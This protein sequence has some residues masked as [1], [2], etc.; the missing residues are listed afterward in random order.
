MITVTSDE[1]ANVRILRATLDKIYKNKRADVTLHSYDKTVGLSEE[2]FGTEPEAMRQPI[3]ELPLTNIPVHYKCQHGTYDHAHN[4]FMPGEEVLILYTG[5]VEDPSEWNCTLIGYPDR[6]KKCVVAGFNTYPR[7][8]PMTGLQYKVGE[9]FPGFGDIYTPYSVQ[10]VA[11]GTSFNTIYPLIDDDGK[12]RYI[13]S[14]GSD[15]LDMVLTGDC[16]NID[17]SNDDEEDL[18]ILTWKGPPSRYFP[19]PSNIEIPGFTE[20]DYEFMTG[21]GDMVSRYMPWSHK[22]YRNGEVIAFGPRNVNYPRNDDPGAINRYGKIIGA[23]LAPSGDKEYVVAAVRSCYI[24]AP[25]NLYAV[26]RQYPEESEGVVYSWHDTQNEADGVVAAQEVIGLWEVREYE[27]VVTENGVVVGTFTDQQEATDFVA[28]Q[29]AVVWTVHKLVSGIWRVLKDGKVEKEFS[30]E[31]EAYA[32]KQVK[33]T[34]TWAITQDEW[35]LTRDGE[36]IDVFSA[37]EDALAAKQRELDATWSVD[38]IARKENKPMAFYVELWVAEDPDIE[39]NWKDASHPG[40]WVEVAAVAV[41]PDV[42]VFFSQDGT[43]C[44]SIMKGGCLSGSVNVGDKPT[45]S[46]T[47]LDNVDGV[48]VHDGK[49]TFKTKTENA[50]YLGGLSVTSYGTLGTGM[51]QHTY[52]TGSGATY[53]DN[54]G[55]IIHYHFTDSDYSGER[56]SKQT[57]VFEGTAAADSIVAADYKNNEVVTATVNVEGAFRWHSPYE[58]KQNWSPLPNG[59]APLRTGLPYGQEEF[60]LGNGFYWCDHAWKSLQYNVN[61]SYKK[62]LKYGDDELVLQD[63]SRLFTQDARH[64]AHSTPGDL[65]WITRYVPGR[66]NL[67]HDYYTKVTGGMTNETYWTSYTTESYHYLDVVIHFMDLRRDVILYR[68]TKDDQNWKNTEQDG[69]QPDNPILMYQYGSYGQA[70]A[71]SSPPVKRTLETKYY[72]RAAGASGY[73]GETETQERWLDPPADFFPMM[74]H[75]RWPHAAETRSIFDFYALSS[76]AVGGDPKDKTWTYMKPSWYDDVGLDRSIENFEYDLMYNYYADENA[77]PDKGIPQHVV[78]VLYENIP[79]G[80]A[81]VHPIDNSVLYS[82]VIDGVAYT[83]YAGSAGTVVPAK[84][85]ILEG[86]GLYNQVTPM[87]LHPI[88]PSER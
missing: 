57:S 49:F 22:I 34:A 78:K 30:K 40:G 21:T 13:T 9:Y 48:K 85:R 46:L 60:V 51:L 73:I 4:V 83:G 24:K 36:V 37:E 33:E 7:M 54:N 12:N 41:K 76:A 35:A 29:G 58:N 63:I 42:P 52:R 45:G 19:F 77:P 20:L 64:G 17:W 75:L 53:D 5:V 50:Q 55:T 28:A 67:F 70:H 14:N 31:G 59:G 11:D 2:D 82:I 79:V 18:R 6:V 86:P 87:A 23:A 15:G 56:G 80:S 32:Y 61:K 66:I 43:K 47:A 74:P 69:Y 65:T 71:V 8:G 3:G 84:A 88:V 81:A 38:T 1:L 16:G 26:M 27:F 62:T 39:G 25:E 44:I 10:G 72:L 68:E